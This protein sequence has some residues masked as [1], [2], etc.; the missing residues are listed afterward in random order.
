[1][2][3][4]GPEEIERIERDHAGG[5]PV[6]AILEIFRPRG[7]QLSE[8]TFRKYVQAGLL[9]RSRRVGR[10]G[11]HQGSRG[12][13]PV[14]SVRRINAIKKMMAEGHT[15]EDIKRSFLFHRNHID[16]L[17]RDL[18]S[19]LDGF[20]S[21]LGGRPFGGDH[22]RTLEDELGALRRRAQDLVRDVARLGSAVTARGDETPDSQ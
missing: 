4:L 20:Q 16:Q 19:V 2:E 17:E 22:R 8:A 12:L 6:R 21:E 5:L 1:M 15:L 14:E 11:K 13:Y 7:V 3:L 18:A 9:P 10:K